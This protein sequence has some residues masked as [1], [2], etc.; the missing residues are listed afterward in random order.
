MDGGCAGGGVAAGGDTGALATGAAV[1]AGASLDA[2]A[3]APVSRLVC[4]LLPPSVASATSAELAAVAAGLVSAGEA[5]PDGF[6]SEG[7]SHAVSA[8]MPAKKTIRAND[9][10]ARVTDKVCCSGLWAALERA[11]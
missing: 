5:V 3:A 9:R 1:V 7:E 2:G 4:V 8:A 11:N 6:V 10:E